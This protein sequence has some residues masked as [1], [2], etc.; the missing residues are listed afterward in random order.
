MTVCVCAVDR[1]IASSAAD[2]EGVAYA[3]TT[4]PG[5]WKETPMSH[6]TNEGSP[7]HRRLL[8]LR[9]TP[10]RLALGVFRLPVA[11]YRHDKGWVLG[12]TFLE[13]TH[14]GR[15]TGQSHDAV[16]M[17]LQFDDA[18]REAVICA[19]WERGPTGSATSKQAQPSRCSTDVTAMCPSTDC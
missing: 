2:G 14:T 8:G 19:A 16:V 15:R 7:Q 12:R 10:G 11:A 3:T 4:G 5:R 6:V 9:R 1:T 13:F 18:T 17:V